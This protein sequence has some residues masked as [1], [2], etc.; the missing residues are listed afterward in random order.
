MTRQLENERIER[1]KKELK[2]NTIISKIKHVQSDCLKYQI[3]KE[4]KILYYPL[5]NLQENFT[6]NFQEGHPEI[7]L[8]L[9]NKKVYIEVIGTEV[10]SRYRRQME[11]VGEAVDENYVTRDFNYVFPHVNPNLETWTVIWKPNNEYTLVRHLSENVSYTTV[12]I[13][14]E[15]NDYHNNVHL[16]SNEEFEK[17]QDKL[18]NGDFDDYLERTTK[19]IISGSKFPLNKMKQFSIHEFMKAISEKQ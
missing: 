17:Y 9:N 12:T 5:F 2:I 19:H 7:V 3:I 8:T 18:M 15:T 6:T 1:E 10:N 4:A 16:M 11:R 13:E 14:E